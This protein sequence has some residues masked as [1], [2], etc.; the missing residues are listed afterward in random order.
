[1]TNFLNTENFVQGLFDFR[2]DFDEIFNQ[3]VSYKP[4][5]Q[6]PSA[7]GKTWNF[8][9]AVE[10]YVDNGAQKYICRVVLP[11]VEPTNVQ[12]HA[13]GNLLTIQGERKLTHNTEEAD[14][15]NEEIVYGVFERVVTI[16]EGVV[17]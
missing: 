1:M 3:M 6:Q 17:T 12:I 2:R 4:W 9:P 11:G 14:F 13:Q 8:V 10:S 15:Q 16:P 5:N 7:F